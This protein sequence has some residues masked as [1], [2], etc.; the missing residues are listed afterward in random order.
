MEENNQVIVD[1]QMDA[2]IAS[3]QELRKQYEANAAAIK[4]LDKESDTY[5]QDVIALTQENKVLKKEMA[6]VESQIQNE[7]KA[8]KAQD[9]SLV[10]LRARLANLN[11]Q[12]DSMSGMER[13]SDAG[14]ALQKQIKALHDQILGLEGATG[15]MQRNVG[16]Y[17]AA[18]Q[19][20][21]EQLNQLNQQM[22]EM[23]KNGK[24]DTTA[25]AALEKSAQALE[26]QIAGL[27]GEVKP[28]KVQL[29]EATNELIQM[30]MRGEENTEQYRQLV[31]KVGQMKDIMT[32]AHDEIKQMASDT[33]MLNSVLDGAKLAAGGFSAALGVMTLFGDED[34]ETA[35]EMAEAQKKL[36]AAIA[37]TTGLQAVQNSLQN[38]SA[39]M[40]GINKIQIWAAAEA[41]DAF[42]AANGR[43]TVA[44]HIFNAV[45][46]SNPYVLLA[47][48]ILSVVGAIAAFTI[49]SKEQEDQMEKTNAEL[50]KQLGI[51]KALK[52]AYTSFYSESITLQERYVEELKLQGA[53]TDEIRKAEDELYKT[54][55][56]ALE[57]EREA[58]MQDITMSGQYMINLATNTERMKEVKASYYQA[59]KDGQES[60]ALSYKQEIDDLQPLIDIDRQRIDSV[61]DFQQRWSQLMLQRQKMEADRRKEEEAAAETARQAALQRAREAEAKRKKEAEDAARYAQ[62]TQQETQKAEDAMNELIENEYDQRK[63]IEETA[64]TRKVKEIQKAMDAEKMAHGEETELYKAYASQKETLAKQHQRTMSNIIMDRT[65][66]EKA[67]RDAAFSM[68]AESN[69]RYWQNR[70]NEAILKGQETGQIELEQL[71]DQLK[72]M[73]QFSE[74]SDEEFKARRLQAQVD[75]LN[76]KKAL[77]EAEKAIE[78]AKAEYMGSIITGIADTMEAVAGDN[79]EL[80]K[81]SKVVALAEV[82]IKQGVAIA[83]AVAASSAGDPYTY[84][85]RVAAAIASTVAAMAKAITSINSASFETGGVIGGYR[86]VTMGKDN[87]YIAARNGEMV[88]NANQQRQLFNIANGSVGTNM[89]AEL[90]AAI[91][92]MPAP[93]LEYSEFQQFAGR[94][95]T[96]NE[97]Q[98][99]K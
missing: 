91:R 57:Q 42:T 55:V 1:V 65:Q 68:A 73:H 54:K 53:S 61:N 97:T 15:R 22:D 82:A 41:Q 33:G 25:F 20:L 2:L 31:E 43:A 79:K 26:S 6:G 7:I 48:V 72:N 19:P 81:A 4:A 49:G 23:Q 56:A 78:K 3:L 40:M 86:G 38:E 70:I 51:V 75:Y 27:G 9:D 11:K 66:K 95:V 5:E 63:A 89:A 8:R 17:P 74:E 69:K 76:K 98:K 96:L 94:V 45:A 16:N 34:S 60:L 64:Y 14:E 24:Q 93:V 67:M 50:E 47:A 10:Q 84:A 99:L 13:M 39:V 29:K 36:Q 71:Q 62:L 28:L 85:L 46:K 12:Y 30:K 92:E 21:V 18:V 59:V 58:L 80:V 90:A 52:E 83:E 77:A 32:D 87:T 44:Q 35:K 88:L 37:V